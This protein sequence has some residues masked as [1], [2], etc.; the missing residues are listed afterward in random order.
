MSRP[1]GGFYLEAMESHGGWIG[2]AIDLMR[3]VTAVDGSRTTGFGQPE[4][5]A[6]AVI[7]PDPPLWQ[8]TDY[9]YGM[10][11]NVQPIGGDAV[12]WHSGSLEGTATILVRTHDGLAWAALF[13]SQPRAS[14]RF[15]SD[16]VKAI[17]RAANQITEWPAHDLFQQYDST[18]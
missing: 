18:P 11:W 9:F 6:L 10:G 17:S 2:S 3:F 13:N 4:A 15:L 8:G 12:W 7:R 14:D 16:L 5:V 1:Y